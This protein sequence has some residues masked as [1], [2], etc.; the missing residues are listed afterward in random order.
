MARTIL[1]FFNILSFKFLVLKKLFSENR[2][3]KFV[4]ALLLN[5]NL[6]NPI[7]QYPHIHESNACIRIFALIF[8]LPR[9][10]LSSFGIFAT[11]K[12]WKYVFTLKSNLRSSNLIFIKIH[13]ILPSFTSGRSFL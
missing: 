5:M 8:L 12:L 11:P 4:K 13:Y 7:L 10:C 2:L 3:V 9:N 6:I 1:N